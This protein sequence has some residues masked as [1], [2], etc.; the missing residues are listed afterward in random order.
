MWTEKNG[1]PLL[2]RYPAS[3]GGTARA[4]WVEVRL[5]L[6]AV[7]GAMEGNSS[8]SGFSKISLSTD[9]VPKVK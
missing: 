8:C 7:A 4:E 3:G 6:Y 9:H 2:V 5:R 1:L